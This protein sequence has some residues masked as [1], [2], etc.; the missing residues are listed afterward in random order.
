MS[1]P[2]G[3]Q[4]YVCAAGNFRGCCTLDPCTTGVCPDDD[5]DDDDGAGDA[6]GESIRR[7][8]PDGAC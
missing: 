7:I 8:Y 3:K 6:D 5:D 1:C 4:Y 2:S